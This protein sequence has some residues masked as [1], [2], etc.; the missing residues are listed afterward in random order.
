MFRIIKVAG[1]TFFLGLQ[2]YLFLIR[3]YD[4][5]DLN[6][7]PN[8]NPTYFICNNHSV[9]QTFK[10]PQ[11]NLHRIDLMFGTYNRTNELK[12]YFQLWEIRGK[13]KI[14]VRQS[15]FRATEVKNNLYHKI[16]FN[17]ISQSKGKLYYFSLSSPDSSPETGI[18]AWMNERNIYRHGNYV[19]DGR[20]KRGDLVF[21]TYSYHNLVSCLWRITRHY[22][23]FLGSKLFFYFVLTFFEAISLFMFYFLLHQF[24]FFLEKGNQP[25][26][27]S[28]AKLEGQRFT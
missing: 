28:K 14:L 7:Y 26:K 1:L 8:T 19:F 10:A 3:K 21:R 2:I 23:G 20:E 4:C 12:I 16:K 24:L 11:N 5:L 9:G 22:P 6:I 27:N 13:R 15:E 18:S 25:S 17:P